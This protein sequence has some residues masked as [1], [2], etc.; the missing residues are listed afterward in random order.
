MGPLVPAS[1]THSIPSAAIVQSATSPFEEWRVQRG[2][3][4]YA[5]CLTAISVGY[6][7]YWVLWKLKAY[8]FG[9]ATCLMV[10]LLLAATGQLRLAGLGRAIVPIA[11][12][13]GYLFLSALWSPSPANTI[14]YAASALINV[15][16]FVVSY[17]WARS[18]SDRALSGYFEFQT[19]LIVPIVLFF[20]VTIGQLYDDSL[21][22]I[23][24]GFAS[25][26]LT[27][28]PFLIWRLRDRMTPVTL[29]ALLLALLFVVTGESR[30][31]LLIAP[32]LVAG[33]VLFVGGRPG[34]RARAVALLVALAVVLG[35]ALLLVPGMRDA[36][37]HSWGRFTSEG[38]NLSI[39]SSILDEITAAP[40]QRVDIERRLQLFIALQSF[41]SHPIIG[42][43]YQ[44][45]FTTIHEQ[46]G[47]EISAHGLPST[48]L[49]ETGLVGTTIFGWMIV[50][51]FR[52]VKR[53][54][55]AT[56]NA[57]RKEFLAT[58]ALTM[59]GLLLLGMFHQVDQNPSLF[60]LLAWGYAAV[61]R[62]RADASHSAGRALPAQA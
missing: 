16:A 37:L 44:S 10:V 40:D 20:L 46:F 13:Y 6:Y 29:V 7:A 3:L 25:T 62:A 1:A 41:L 57:M 59:I 39:S 50:R 53:A 33:S 15:V 32:I 35:A 54:R 18:A 58:C 42:G 23:R 56:A 36:V 11:V 22:A 17:A 52:R 60:V 48:L 43:G 45:T 21:G 4:F 19:Y 8:Y 27:A 38:T 55:H 12:W 2:A 5:L 14:Y 30:S 31:G 47:W 51:F 28:L 61:G 9:W 34:G 26:C 49:G 24:T